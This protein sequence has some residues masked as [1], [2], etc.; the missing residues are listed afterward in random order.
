MTVLTRPWEREDG[1]TSRGSRITD[2]VPRIWQM[3]RADCGWQVEER[4]E[5]LRWWKSRTLEGDR[6]V[7]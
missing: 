2:V 4:V 1:T 5:V 3:K 7:V 6:I